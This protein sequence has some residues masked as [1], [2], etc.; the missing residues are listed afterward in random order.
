[1]SRIKEMLCIRR[2][3]FENFMD[4]NLLEVGASHKK[5]R[6][7]QLLEFDSQIHSTLAYKTSDAHG[8]ILKFSNS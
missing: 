7:E 8:P 4:A 2:S 3:Q 5:E 1:M 6:I